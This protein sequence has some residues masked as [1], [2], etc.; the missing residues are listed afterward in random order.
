MGVGKKIKRGGDE[1]KG[2]R[3][4][5]K[6]SRKGGGIICFTCIIYTAYC[7]NLDVMFPSGKKLPCAPSELSEKCRSSWRCLFRLQGDTCLGI[8]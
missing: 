2:R 5:P 3:N 7:L 1:A 6:F 4:P 8:D